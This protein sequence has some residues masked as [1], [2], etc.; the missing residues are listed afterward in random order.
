MDENRYETLI[1]DM[2]EERRNTR[3]S[4]FKWFIRFTVVFSAL[5]LFGLAGFKAVNFSGMG[6]EP[7]GVLLNFIFLAIPGIL[8][9]SGMIL[10]RMDLYQIPPDKKSMRQAQKLINK[11]KNTDSE[12]TY[13][14]KNSWSPEKVEQ[15]IETRS[16]L[17]QKLE[18]CIERNGLDIDLHRITSDNHL[19]RL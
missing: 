5:I 13:L 19:P 8:L 1:D 12:I 10:W 14:H 3:S 11:I 2:N 9:I 15:L 7:L 6:F 17:C 16:L 4:F 18:Q